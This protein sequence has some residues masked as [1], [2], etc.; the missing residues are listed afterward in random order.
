VTVP[1]L[2][3][4][5]V[6]APGTSCTIDV[7]PQ[8]PVVSTAFNNGYGYLSGFGG[9]GGV[10]VCRLEANG[11]LDNCIT[12]ASPNRPGNYGQLAVH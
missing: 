3:A 12:G 9:G 5:C 7:V 6:L 4:T 1:M 2:P 8:T 10:G 11:L